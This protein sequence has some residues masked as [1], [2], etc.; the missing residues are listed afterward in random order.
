[1]QAKAAGAAGV[2]SGGF[3]PDAYLRSKQPTQATPAAEAPEE[4]PSFGERVAKTLGETAADTVTGAAQIGSIA[5]PLVAAAGALG[6]YV[7]PYTAPE[8]A[9][10]KERWANEMEGLRKRREESMQRSPV[11]FTA[12]ALAPAALAPQALANLPSASGSLSSAAGPLSRALAGGLDAAIYSGAYAAG[13]NADKDPGRAAFEA[14]TS[15]TT[16]GVG[17]GLPMAAEAIPAMAGAMRSGGEKVLRRALAPLTRN[18]TVSPAARALE[19]EGIPLTTGQMAPDSPLGAVEERATKTFALGPGLETRRAQSMDAWRKAVLRRA[20]P[21]GMQELPEGA[22]QDQLAALYAGFEPAYEKIA[23]EPIYPAIHRGGKGIALQSTG[24]GPGA[25]DEVVADPNIITD[26]ATRAA[27]KR[28]LDNQ[29][30]LLPGGTQRP[31]MLEPVDVSDMLKLRSNIRTAGRQADAGGKY[32]LAN[33]LGNAE[34][35]VTD[36]IASQLKAKHAQHLLTTLE[37]TDRQYAKLAT[38]LNAAPREVTA[39][40]FTPRQLLQ[41]VR[42][43]AGNRAYAQGHGGELQRLG[44]NAA[45]VFDAR[46]PPTGA[47]LLGALPG[48]KIP[49]G[50]AGYA[51]NTPTGRAL[52]LGEALPSRLPMAP[53]TPLNVPA[54]GLASLLAGDEGGP[55]VAA[56]IRALRL[57]GA[58]ASADEEGRR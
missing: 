43:S 49:T 52:L 58:P 29:L 23:G 7:V 32:D 26:E 18:V 33:I 20:L 35:A 57:R 27:A 17:A 40:D 11:A 25:F 12:G 34:Q 24:K 54:S 31:N 37:A 41:A 19:A 5:D 14:M 38:V 45:A 48:G 44:Q 2:A 28:F 22:T 10:F 51:M 46:T 9:T 8:G 1:M 3:D 53:M 6:S 47:M 42:Q 16:V 13:Q 55:D 15:P 50:L 39:G 56:L 36:S 4:P 30:S 21:P